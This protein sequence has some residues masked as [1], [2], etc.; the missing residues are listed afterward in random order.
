MNWKAVAEYPAEPDYP[1]LVL[2]G[3]LTPTNVALAV[4]AVHPTAVDTAS[5]VESSPGHKDPA[6]V[7][8]FVEAS[9]AA[10]RG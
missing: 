9:Q 2:A 4:A 10:L 3:G 6:L 1:P 8:A 7:R 5:G